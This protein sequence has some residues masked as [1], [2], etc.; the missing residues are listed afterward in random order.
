MKMESDV[1][2]KIKEL[3]QKVEDM[4]NLPFERQHEHN[5]LHI[6]TWMAQIKALNWVTNLSQDI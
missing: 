6:N 4:K 2:T 5:Y 3:E 1:L